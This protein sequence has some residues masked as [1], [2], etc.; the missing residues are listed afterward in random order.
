MADPTEVPELPARLRAPAPVIVAGMVAWL[1]A[2][3]VVAATGIGPDR[4]LSVC[5]VGLA[6]GVLGTVIVLVQQAA[7]NRGSRGA[8]EGLDRS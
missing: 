8:Q 1:V 6:V 4:A 7:V 5:L 3:V 2:T